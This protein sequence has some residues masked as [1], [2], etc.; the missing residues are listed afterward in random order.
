V[1]DRTLQDSPGERTRGAELTETAGET[2]G[3]VRRAASNLAET[4]KQQAGDVVGEA[5]AQTRGVV[6]D[7]R[8]RLTDEVHSQNE[9]L[10]GGIRQV[11][12]QLTEMAGGQGDSTARMLVQRLGEGGRQVAD[13]LE[14]NG[15]EGVL[16]EVQEFARRRPGV[17]LLGAALT[18]FVVGRLGKGVLGAPAGGNGAP[19][20]ATATGNGRTRPVPVDSGTTAGT[21]YAG[22]AA[23]DQAAAQPGGSPQAPMD[24]GSRP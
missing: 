6:A 4:A 2:A 10:A 1:E 24:R 18:G 5:A 11:A 20:V 8:H 9:R 14:R 16:T 13:Y 23:V 3:S 15:P 21:V 22:S 17:F 19:A 12:D 7:A